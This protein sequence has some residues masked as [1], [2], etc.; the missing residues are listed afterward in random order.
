[1][2]CAQI[3]DGGDAF[4]GCLAQPGGSV[5]LRGGTLLQAMF[6]DD[7]LYHGF[8]LPHIAVEETVLPPNAGRQARL[9]AVACTPLF[10]WDA[11]TP[12]C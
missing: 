3:V 6:F 2:L 4:L 7:L 8:I 12:R 5:L 9:E 11:L 1:M 10:G